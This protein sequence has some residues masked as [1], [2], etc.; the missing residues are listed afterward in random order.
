MNAFIVSGLVER[1]A[2]LAGEIER[3]REALAAWCRTWRG[4]E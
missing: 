1:R 4:L 2:E 3:T